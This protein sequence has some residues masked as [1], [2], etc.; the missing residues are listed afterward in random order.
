ME[1]WKHGD[2]KHGNMNMKHGNMEA[3]ETWKHE[4]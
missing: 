1:A 2:M 3:Y 4:A